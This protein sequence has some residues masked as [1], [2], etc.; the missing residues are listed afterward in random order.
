MGFQAFGGSMGGLDSHTE[1]FMRKNPFDLKG[2]APTSLVTVTPGEVVQGGEHITGRVSPRTKAL[3]K[4]IQ[5]FRPWRPGGGLF[6]SIRAA[7]KRFKFSD[8]ARAAEGMTPEL[9]R[10]SWSGHY[11]PGWFGAEDFIDEML[12]GDRSVSVL[13]PK[14][15]NRGEALERLREVGNVTFG[16]LDQ[17]LAGVR[18]RI[19]PSSIADTVESIKRKVFGGEPRLGTQCAGGA[20]RAVL[21]RGARNIPSDLR[22]MKELDVVGELLPDA[23]AAQFGSLKN[24]RKYMAARAR[25]TSLPGLAAALG[26]GGLGTYGLLNRKSN[27]QLPK[28]R[29]I[30]NSIA[31][32]KK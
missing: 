32:G 13:R 18:R 9:F 8:P 7:H 2:L 20:C 24:M 12:A 10:K 29:Q 11:G 28:W 6:D 1:M 21:G 4:F 27:V 5:Q 31:E 15:F 14:S 19:I 3:K 30:L 26:I 23:S 22:Y 25:L 16:E 17:Q